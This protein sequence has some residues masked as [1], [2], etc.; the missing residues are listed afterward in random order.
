MLKGARNVLK[1]FSPKL[2]VCTYHLPDDPQVLRD[3]ILEA[4]P[5]Y[6]VEQKYK[7]IYAYVPRC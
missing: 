5:R 4:N 6:R 7:K 2:A 3:L 1:E